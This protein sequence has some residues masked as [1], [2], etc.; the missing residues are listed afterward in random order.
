[1]LSAISNIFEKPRRWVR[2]RIQ[3]GPLNRLLH[4]RR[5]QAY[6]VG[7]AKSG[8]TSIADIFSRSY[9]AAHEPDYVRMIETILATFG[10]VDR[11]GIDRFLRK[12]DQQL[13]LEM[14]SSQLCYFF[15]EHLVR[16]FPYARFL[17]TIR[18]CRSWLDS[19]IN[20]QLARPLSGER[21]AEYWQKLRDLRF[22]T[23]LDRHPEPERPLAERDLYTLD[24][25]FSYWATHNQ[26]IIDMVPK[27]RLLIVRTHEIK[28]S[29]PEFADFL[30]VPAESLDSLRGHTNRAIGKFN[31][32]SLIDP[33]YLAGKIRQHCGKL[34]DRFFADFP[35][36]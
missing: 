4:P 30:Q 14:E 18:D 15:V 34:M 27:E 29:I 5:F 9:Q 33:D 1:M 19:L 20:H 36:C 28:Q 3:I 26:R 11:R 17:L 2:A 16:V 31:V 12:R 23:A 6:C 24:G 25:Y 22:G 32:L 13:W 35:G 7:T 10:T 8:T 21:H